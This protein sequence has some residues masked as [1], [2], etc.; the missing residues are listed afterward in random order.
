MRRPCPPARKGFRLPGRACVPGRPL[1]A[2][3][4]FALYDLGDTRMT[5]HDTTNLI[6]L[7]LGML[8]YAE[9]LDCE[10][11]R[12]PTSFFGEPFSVSKPIREWAANCRSSSSGA[13]NAPMR[14]SILWE[15]TEKLSSSE[16]AARI[17]GE[18]AAGSSDPDS[19][20]CLSVPA[21]TFIAGRSTSSF[22]LA[23]RLLEE[24]MLPEW[25]AV[26]CSC[27]TEGRGQLRRHWHSP[28]GNLYATF[29]LPDVPLFHGDTAALTVGYLLLLAF[30]SM[31]FPLSLKWPNDLMLDEKAKIGGILLEERSGV[32]LAGVGINL[33]EA[34]SPAQLRAQS[35]T[36]PAVLLPY[37]VRSVKD[38][39]QESELLICGRQIA[40]GRKLSGESSVPG[41]DPDEPLAPFALWR[42]L[43]S[44]AILA[45]TN[46]VAGSEKAS[47]LA[48]LEEM[49]I[50]KG[51]AVV[52]AE[53]GVD[54]SAIRGRFLGLGERGGLLLHDATGRPGE[55]FSG[56]LALDENF[57]GY[58][59]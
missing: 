52:L 29:R 23:W 16:L 31:G 49:L 9:P 6:A 50:W 36:H 7:P 24:G 59:G 33:A 47:V 40:D 48:A 4:T 2:G 17:A 35:A 19:S 3:V 14:Y 39:N 44:R 18:G 57:S 8:P 58:T 42:H 22:A 56:S 53:E 5:L 10:D 54:G 20:R 27:Q 30:R 32:V 1:V 43:V 38:A 45:Y 11:L 37:H 41:D 25:G 55:Y 21:S 28:R 12:G 46:C 51:R 15:D 26:L 34:P 13:G